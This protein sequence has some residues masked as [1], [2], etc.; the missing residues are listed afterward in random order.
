M[1]G[2]HRDV[3]LA[4]ELVTHPRLKWQCRRGMREL[5]ELLLRY[6][7]G[8]YDGAPA[9][10]KQAFES[11]LS[12]SDPELVQYLL[13]RNRPEDEAIAHVVSCIRGHDTS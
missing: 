6:L 7:E 12:L 10:E 8:R 13:G 1:R 2:R 4:T 9:A 5:D 11:L 3:D